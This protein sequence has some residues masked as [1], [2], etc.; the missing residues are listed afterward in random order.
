MSAPVNKFLLTQSLLSSWQWALKREGGMGDFLTTLRREPTKQT[1]AMLDGI[2]FENMVAATLSGNPPDPI[3]KW[4]DGINAVADRLRGAALQV[5]LSRDIEVDGVRFLL[6]GVLDALHAGEI[7]DIKFSRT[8]DVGK[9][10]PSPQTP[11]YF[12]LCPEATRFTYLVSD[13]TYLYREWYHPDEIPSIETHIRGFMRFLENMKLID[14]YTDKW[15]S[16]E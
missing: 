8:Y 11:A 10:F 13:G 16:K 15:R 9:Y 3:H 1:Q 5:K 6:Y 7:Y 4:R 12:Y 2:Q 14:L